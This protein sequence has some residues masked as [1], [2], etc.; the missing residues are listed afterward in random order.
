NVSLLRVFDAQGVSLFDSTTEV[1]TEFVGKEG[2]QVGNST[3]SVRFEL[4]LRAAQVAA[5]EVR[6]QGAVCDLMPPTGIPD[7]AAN[8]VDALSAPDAASFLSV[9]H[10]G[11]ALFVAGHRR[12]ILGP[13]TGGVADGE[14]ENRVG[15]DAMGKAKA[16]ADQCTLPAP[17]AFP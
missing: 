12:E 3:V 9:D 5:Y 13:R 4:A 8:A 1:A 11:A 17:G 10:E 16:A 2:V 15:Y 14:G 6:S 7:A